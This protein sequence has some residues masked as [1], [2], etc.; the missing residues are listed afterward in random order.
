MDVTICIG[1]VNNETPLVTEL[2]PCG[3]CD[4]NINVVEFLNGNE[5]PFYSVKLFPIYIQ[6]I[7]IYIELVRYNFTKYLDYIMLMLLLLTPTEE[8]KSEFNYLCKLNWKSLQN[9]RNKCHLL[10]RP[11][12]WIHYR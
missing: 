9:S 5:F 7:N 6:S 8:K 4:V 11:K 1:N 10:T 12:Q 3:V 2:F